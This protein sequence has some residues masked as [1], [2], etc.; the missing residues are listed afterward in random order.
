MWFSFFFFPSFSWWPNR[1]SDF[2]LSFKLI[3]IYMMYVCFLSMN[4]LSMMSKIKPVSRLYYSISNK[5][6]LVGRRF[7]KEC[8][9]G[10][11]FLVKLNCFH[12]DALLILLLL[13]DT[14]DSTWKILHSVHYW[15]TG[16]SAE[17]QDSI[18]LIIFGSHQ[19]SVIMTISLFRSKWWS[20]WIS[21]FN[22]CFLNYLMSAIRSFLYCFLICV[23]EKAPGGD[24]KIDGSIIISQKF[25]C[26]V[27]LFW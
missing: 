21:V 2:T 25:Q 9:T 24:A 23:I 22:V 18:H 4:F 11:W 5:I 27:F 17:F 7:T 12:V 8:N 15:W 16:F 1:L 10:Y 3:C 13:Q 14:T 26:W 20:L 19:S 6:K